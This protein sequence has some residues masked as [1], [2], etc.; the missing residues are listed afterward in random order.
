MKKTYLEQYL[1]S[2]RKD[3]K[4]PIKDLPPVIGIA[5]IAHAQ[6]AQPLLPDYE[7]VINKYYTHYTVKTLKELPYKLKNIS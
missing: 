2:Q 3:V 6:Y 1:A 5:G 4:H 7:I